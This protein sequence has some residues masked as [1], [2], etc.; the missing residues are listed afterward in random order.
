MIAAEITRTGMA[1]HSKPTEKPVMMVVAGPVLQL[2]AIESTGRY[3]Y[4]V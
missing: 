1:V 3:L 2:S 4:S